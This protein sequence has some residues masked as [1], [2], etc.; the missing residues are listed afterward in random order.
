MTSRLMARL[1]GLLRTVVGE[2]VQIEAVQ[3][4]TLLREADQ[5]ASDWNRGRSYTG[6]HHD[7]GT[8]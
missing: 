5:A 3:A 7:G 2:D 6:W 1:V 8:N 4:R